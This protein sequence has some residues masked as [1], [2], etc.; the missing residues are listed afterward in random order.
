VDAGVPRLPFVPVSLEV[1]QK[2]KT[3]LQQINL[4]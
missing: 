3:A 4:L 1:V 2:V